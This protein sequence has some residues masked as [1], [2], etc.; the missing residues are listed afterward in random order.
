MKLTASLFLLIAIFAS[1]AAVN[2]LS[3]QRIEFT[4]SDVA[5]AAERLTGHRASMTNDIHLIAGRRLAGPAITMRVVRDDGASLMEEGLKAIKILES[6]PAGSVI[7]LALDDDKS[8]AVFGSTFATLAK[9]RRL[10]G[11]VVDGSM[12]GLPELRRLAF[13]TF[14]RGTTPGSAGGHY[15]LAGVNVSIVCGDI[16]VS[17]GDFVVGDEDG[18]AV[19][20]KQLYQ[21]V[22]T[23]AKGLR[24]EK[25]EILPLIVKYGSYT[26]AMQEYAEA[27]RKRN[28][29]KR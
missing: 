23:R 14:A 26:K 19:A 25:Q 20:P 24:L 2:K 13:A 29:T 17:P 1:S 6:A 9:S 5:D 21:E 16:E 4:S 10:A 12:R 8:F 15:R 27:V 28:A 3:A 22:L 7:V 11:F 18:V